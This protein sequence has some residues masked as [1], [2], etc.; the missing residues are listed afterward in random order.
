MTHAQ[1]TALHALTYQDQVLPGRSVRHLQRVPP[2]HR[3]CR[4]QSVHTWA[5]KCPTEGRCRVENLEE[6]AQEV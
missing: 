6:V 3:S 4:S 2:P 5:G 1:S